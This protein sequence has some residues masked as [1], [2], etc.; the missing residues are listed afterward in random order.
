MIDLSAR[1][2]SAR[3]H[4]DTTLATHRA[5]RAPQAREPDEPSARRRGELEAEA[6][7]KVD[8]RYG[9]VNN[10]ITFASRSTGFKCDTR[11]DLP[12]G[13]MAP[14]P[15]IP[16]ESSRMENNWAKPGIRVSAHTGSL[17]RR[18]PLAPMGP[19][20]PSMRHSALKA[21]ALRRREGRARAGPE[22][23]AK[24]VAMPYA[25]KSPRKAGAFSATATSNC[26][27]RSRTKRQSGSNEASAQNT[28]A[29]NSN[30]PKS[31]TSA[32]Y[33]VHSAH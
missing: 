29:D 6:A 25:Q 18:W 27:V 15:W 13:N 23:P 30:S 12:F 3:T 19:S 22:H 14:P 24:G 26:R 8:Q 32:W 31:H 33:V 21:V 20:G 1:K 28:A 4:Q 5:V 11:L 9:R 2:L 17:L 7:R 10:F 16:G